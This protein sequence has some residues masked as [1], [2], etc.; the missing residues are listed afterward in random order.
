MQ[1]KLEMQQKNSL[2]SEAE[3]QIEESDKEE[4]DEFNNLEESELEEERFSDCDDYFNVDGVDLDYIP[5]CE[6]SDDDDEDL[7]KSFS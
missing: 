3:E 5:S 7:S 1:Q 2:E 6:T 4:I